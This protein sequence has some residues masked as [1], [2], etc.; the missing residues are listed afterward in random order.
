MQTL[1]PSTF[2]VYQY[3][4]HFKTLALEAT[5]SLH[6]QIKDNDAF[7]GYEG[8]KDAFDQL[9]KEVYTIARYELFDGAEI[10][11]VIQ[12]WYTY[13]EEVCNGYRDADWF[14]YV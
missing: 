7:L 9:Y 1:T 5:I 13:M 3:E 2:N 11:Q 12:T 4:Q 8:D 14:E 6:N 10:E